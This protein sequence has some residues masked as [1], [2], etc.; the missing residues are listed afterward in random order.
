MVLVLQ[1]FTS[2]FDAI[3]HSRKWVTRKWQSASSGSELDGIFL[4]LEVRIVN[5]VLNSGRL[6]CDELSKFGTAASSGA[7][8]SSSA[9]AALLTLALAA[10]LH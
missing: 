8:S 5:S 2:G 7:A 4:R 10:F 1:R 9:P 3:G 6:M